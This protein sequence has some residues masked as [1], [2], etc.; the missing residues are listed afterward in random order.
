LGTVRDNRPKCSIESINE[1][2]GAVPGTSANWRAHQWNLALQFGPLN[3][4]LGEEQLARKLARRA[5][6][7]NDEDRHAWLFSM[8]K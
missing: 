7:G 3:A 8:P 1:I 2:N 4:D 6:V 5:L